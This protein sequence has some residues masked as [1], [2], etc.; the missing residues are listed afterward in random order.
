LTGLG[1][2]R[3]HFGVLL[4]ALLLLF[5]GTAFL[6]YT[7][8]YFHPALLAGLSSG[9]LAFA[10]IT[11]VMNVSAQSAGWQVRVIQILV[12]ATVLSH[13]VSTQ[14][15]RPGLHVVPRVMA[16]LCFGYTIAVVLGYLLRI[17]KVGADAINAAVCVFLLMGVTW[18]LWYGFVG[19]FEEQA[20]SVSREEM[21]SRPG[22]GYL[23]ID[24]LYFSM[25]TLTTLGY[26]DVT[27]IT[28]AARISAVLEATV[29]Q[30]FMVVLVARLVGLQVSQ[31]GGGE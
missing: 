31:Q 20:F 8:T 18:A 3:A 2:I 21:E 12:A 7:A 22:G 17:K 13:I 19:S 9:L 15:D 26:G 10:L 4:V 5:V 11:A 6:D 16:L 24:M 25:V 28:T 30:I 1:G 23:S 29:G 27:P 14:L